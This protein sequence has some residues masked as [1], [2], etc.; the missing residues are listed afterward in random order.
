M[1]RK[2]RIRKQL[3]VLEGRGVIFSWYAQSNMPGMRWTVE[4][5][6]SGSRSFSTSEVEAFLVGAL[7]YASLFR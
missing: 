1:N 6:D 2:D 5:R 4:T 3:D 7:A